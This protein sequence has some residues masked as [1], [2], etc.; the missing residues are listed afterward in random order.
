MSSIVGARRSDVSSCLRGSWQLQEFGS[1]L[2]RSWEEGS[3][4]LGAR[5]PWTGSSP[6][7][8]GEEEERHTLPPDGIGLVA[9]GREVA[10]ERA[11]KRHIECLVPTVAAVAACRSWTTRT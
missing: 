11:E 2:R 6:G 3:G 8:E 7:T 4:G 10:P 1:E 9:R 5:D